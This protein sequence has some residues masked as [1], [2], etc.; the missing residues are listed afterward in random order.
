VHNLIL[1]NPIR[2]ISCA[3]A[4]VGLAT[5][6][7]SSFTLVAKRIERLQ[8]VLHAACCMLLCHERLIGRQ[9]RTLKT[10]HLLASITYR[11]LSAWKYLPT[12]VCSK[13]N[14]VSPS[15]QT[16]AHHQL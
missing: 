10:C 12:L 2:S 13:L 16:Q 9:V 6:F 7:T 11:L 14:D 3:S 8:V 1:C 5:S 4:S 15:L